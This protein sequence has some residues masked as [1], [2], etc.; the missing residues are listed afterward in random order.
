MS[1]DV[2]RTILLSRT[3]YLTII[4]QEQSTNS[5]VLEPEST[6]LL[7]LRVSLVTTKRLVAY[8]ELEAD[9]YV[10]N[11]DG[12]SKLR[13]LLVNRVIVG[14]PHKRRQNATGLTE[15]PCGHHS[16]C[17]SKYQISCVCL[18]IRRLSANQEWT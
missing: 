14:N 5:A 10:L 16:V 2:V 18:T 6:P 9:D 7:V 4:R 17:A 15:P 11:E 3:I 1:R 12:S 13:V 8:R